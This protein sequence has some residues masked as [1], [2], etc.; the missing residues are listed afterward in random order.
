MSCHW[1]LLPNKEKLST[2]RSL[3]TVI[4]AV[5]KVTV[6]TVNLW[7]SKY[8]LM[9]V[10]SDKHLMVTDLIII[11]TILENTVM[12]RVLNNRYENDT[13]LLVFSVHH[14]AQSM[15]QISTQHLRFSYLQS[16]RKSL[17]WS[18]TKTGHKCGNVMCIWQV[19][20][21]PCC[22]TA[23]PHVKSLNPSCNP[24]STRHYHPNES[25]IPFICHAAFTQWYRIFRGCI[26]DTSFWV[27]GLLNDWKDFQSKTKMAAYWL[28]GWET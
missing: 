22:S 5:V 26:L 12:I 24:Q 13:L 8:S 19:K 17:W 20:L 1:R 11:C 9:W 15:D 18:K 2:S 7:A 28:P 25:K 23:P 10:S 3:P 4:S 27:F 6:F 21:S 16:K 14:F